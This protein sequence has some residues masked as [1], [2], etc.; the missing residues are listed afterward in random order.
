MTERERER[1]GEIQ[2]ENSCEKADRKK[3][4]KSEKKVRKT[5]KLQTDRVYYAGKMVKHY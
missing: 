2:V 3:K 5:N 4:K 1:G